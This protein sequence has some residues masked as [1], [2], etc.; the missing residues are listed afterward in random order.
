MDLAS[1]PDTI[2]ISNLGDCSLKLSPNTLLDPN[3][4]GRMYTYKPRPTTV[5]R[6]SH[7]LGFDVPSMNAV[8]ELS[9]MIPIKIESHVIRIR[10]NAINLGEPVRPLLFRSCRSTRPMGRN[11]FLPIKPIKDGLTELAS[12]VKQSWRRS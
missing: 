3:G 4:L 8:L 5:L 6:D 10:I 2:V 1:R 9:N 11:N 12:K 7:E